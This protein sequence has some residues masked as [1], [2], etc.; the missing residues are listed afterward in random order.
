MIVIDNNFYDAV[1][2]GEINKESFKLAKIYGPGAKF[3]GQEVS[4]KFIPLEGTIVQF[5]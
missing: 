1:L 2:R 3:P 4:F 5:V